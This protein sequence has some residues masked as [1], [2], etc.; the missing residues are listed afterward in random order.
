MGKM[1]VKDRIFEAI[2]LFVK[3]NGTCQSGIVL[4]KDDYDVLKA[5]AGST[6]LGRFF[7]Q[8]G[9]MFCCLPVQKGDTE[10]III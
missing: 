8:R 9:F 1:N 3:K 5:E 7:L 10:I 4:P 6:V 2:E